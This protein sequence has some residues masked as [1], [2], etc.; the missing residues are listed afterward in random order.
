MP[1]QQ[2]WILAPSST[3][4]FPSLLSSPF[5]FTSPGWQ[6]GQASN[7]WQAPCT[8]VAPVNT[9]M[10]ARH[11]KSRSTT[12]KWHSLFL[13]QFQVL[14]L[15]FKVQHYLDPSYFKGQLCPH[16]PAQALGSVLPGFLVQLNT[17]SLDRISGTGRY[18]RLFLWLINRPLKLFLFHMTLA[19]FMVVISTIILGL[20]FYDYFY[21]ILNSL[22]NYLGDSFV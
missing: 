6:A 17:Y 8:V 12:V 18:S 21:C 4:P 7:T 20:L 10:T 14:V 3:F 5:P 15:I 9:Q 19:S 16:E 11:E 1:L 2:R 13:G 22:I